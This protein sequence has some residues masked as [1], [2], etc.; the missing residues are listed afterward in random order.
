MDS[1][2]ELAADF[3]V[4][5]QIYCVSNGAELVYIGAAGRVKQA[6]GFSDIALFVVGRTHHQH[7]FVDNDRSTCIGQAAEVHMHHS[8][9]RRGICRTGAL[10]R[11][12]TDRSR[13][14]PDA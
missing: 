2:G 4:V 5:G 1:R 11:L 12:T 8:V 13:M 6:I 3:L 7:G 9:A 14:R 10:P